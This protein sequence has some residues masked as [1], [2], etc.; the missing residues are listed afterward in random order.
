MR[1]WGDTLYVWICNQ[2]SPLLRASSM[3]CCGN[4]TQMHVEKENTEDTDF[5]HV[6]AREFFT[7]DV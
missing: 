2:I 5:V 3:S 7:H 1:V 4:I 6:D